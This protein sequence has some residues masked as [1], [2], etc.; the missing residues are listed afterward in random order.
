MDTGYDNKYDERDQMSK[1][2]EEKVTEDLEV[3]KLGN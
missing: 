3:L 1:N 2:D